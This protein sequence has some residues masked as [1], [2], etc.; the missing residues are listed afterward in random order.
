MRVRFFAAAIAV[1]AGMVAAPLGSAA[2]PQAAAPQASTASPIPITGTTATGDIFS[3]TFTPTAV[4]IVNGELAV[5]GTLT[6]TITDL[7]GNVIGTVNQTITAPLAVTGTCSV[8][9]LTIGPVDLNLLGLVV[10][11]DT[12][13]LTVDAQ[14]GPGNLV[15]NLVCAVS[16]LLDSGASLT[17]VTNL[18]NIIL[19]LI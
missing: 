5:V 18:L 2:P 4:A 3:G 6:G 19:G 17:A 9:N 8:L 7:L 11:L 13:H 15:G 14:S 16:H 1:A 12:V 10:H